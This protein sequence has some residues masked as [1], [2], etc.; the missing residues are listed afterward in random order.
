MPRSRTL[1]AIAALSLAL[2]SSASCGSRPRLARR[3]LLVTIDTLR[4][5]RLGVLGG[6][7]ATPNLDR[8]AK[9]GV[10]FTNAVAAAPQTL[11][12]HASILSALYPPAHGARSNGIFRLRDD[13]ETIAEVFETA[14][15]DTGAFVGAFVLDRRFGLTQGFERYDDELPDEN[16]VHK[17]YYPERPAGEIV[18]L[19]TK[20]IGERADAPFFVW[21]HTFDPHAPYQ[22]PP[23]FDEIYRDRLY[24]G[25]I[26]YTDHALGALIDLVGSME[27][28]LIVVTA[29]HGESL[30][31]HGESTHGLYIYDSTVR[32]PLILKGVGIPAG[33]RVGAQ[34]RTVDIAP[35]VAEVAGLEFS[36][37]VDG[38][39]LVPTLSDAP[40]PPRTAYFESLIP[41]LHFNWS[42]LRG[43]RT[44]ARK[45]I[46]APK[47][48]L[49]DLETDPQE[50]K[51][52]WGQSLLEESD[53]L[54]SDL[55]ALSAEDS[56]LLPTIALDAE[57]ASRLESLG[58]AAATAPGA[59]DERPRPD[60][61]D[62]IEV[63]ER[64]QELLSPELT[65]EQ[66][67]QG[68]RQILSDEP[69]NALARNRLANTLSEEKRLEEAVT[70]YERLL[71][72]SEIDFTGFENLASALLLSGR[73]EDALKVTLRA[74]TEAP[75]NPDFQTLRAEAL[76][77]AG[78]VK[79][80]RSAYDAALALE[81]SP[82]GYWRR[83]ALAQKVGELDTA[84][85][86]L[87]A[88]LEL[89]RTFEPALAA[90]ARLLR[91]TGRAEEARALLDGSPP[92]IDRDTPVMRA[93]YAEL[94]LAAGRIDEAKKLLESARFEAPDNAR[95][96]ALLGPI[97]GREGRLEEASAVLRRALALGETAPEIRRNLALIYLRQRKPDA[98]VEELRAAL[99]TAPQDATL[100]YSLGNVYLQ[101]G[102][103]GPAAEAFSRALELQ[104]R[105]PE[106][107]FHLGMAADGANRTE[108]AVAAF[109]MFLDEGDPAD[110]ERRAE[111][112]KRLTRLEGEH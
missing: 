103:Y 43:L 77:R 63:Y 99:E 37:P 55:E 66:A 13:V 36:R 14:G 90:L 72:D 41:R 61:K 68:Y 27:E 58:Y 11:P 76:E 64:M 21:V 19:A 100:W 20:W 56:E 47:P 5:D 22:P 89:D 25:E 98:A 108:E 102:R 12:S 15:F 95:V 59:S 75:W 92:A 109:Q 16:P 74:I 31:E 4:W 70:E 1:I 112:R 96:L 2:L 9:S 80:A 101:S 73:V 65:A 24:D 34:V 46:R 88:A 57:T 78:L 111:A 23:P 60:P 29:D 18:G 35:T 54:A 49:Y 51:N 6:D 84:E 32:V 45:Y 48:E 10:L 7:V 50:E 42:E 62:R 26:A 87:R 52:L 67:I 44:D 71:T 69:K 17:I 83:G 93:A 106:A 105:W 97:Y 38:E 3:I 86:D 110:V 85:K 82:D 33:K 40:A 91:E 8:L 104:P 94:A 28:S 30:G 107:A 39:S 53:R 79:E 81:S